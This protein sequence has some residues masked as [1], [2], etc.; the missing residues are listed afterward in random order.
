MPKFIVDVHQHWLPLELIPGGH[1]PGL[2]RFLAMISGAPLPRLRELDDHTRVVEA[3]GVVSMLHEDLCDIDLANRVNA[4]AGVDLRILLPSMQVVAFSL[5]SGRPMLETSKLVH[6]IYAELI[7]RM[8]GRFVTLASISPFEPQG[9]KEA[10]RAINELAFRGL[11]IDTN[12]GGRFYD[13]EDVYPF[14]EFAEANGHA[15]WVHP[16]QLPYGFEIMKKWRLE[17]V[18]GRPCDTGMSVARMIYSG[19]LDRFP[20]TKIVLAHMGGTTVSLLGR[21]DFGYRLGYAGLPPEMHARNALRPSEYMRRNFYVDTMGFN[22]P[23]LKAALDVFGA[24]RLLFGSDY[25]PVPI[26]PK[27]H[28]DIVNQLPLNETEREDVF[29]RTADRLFRLKLDECPTH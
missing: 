26:S 22:L 9:L 19:L 6:D 18:V 24:D 1:L 14:F 29:W 16:A 8:P 11:C 12:W 27:E 17:E 23:M 28:I 15:I 3:M 25:G 5:A 20:K 10:E 13:T 21:L 2:R 7:A 4:E